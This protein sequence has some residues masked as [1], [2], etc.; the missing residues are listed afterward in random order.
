MKA[1]SYLLPVGV[2][3]TIRVHPGG[4]V[5]LSLLRGTVG[6][7]LVIPT[8]IAHNCCSIKYKVSFQPSVSGGAGIQQTQHCARQRI[9]YFIDLF[10]H[11]KWEGKSCGFATENFPLNS[12]QVKPW[13]SS[14]SSSQLFSSYVLI[15]GRNLILTLIHL[16]KTY[17]QLRSLAEKDRRCSN[18]LQRKATTWRAQR[19][20]EN[21]KYQK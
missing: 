20:S 10:H 15:C 21:C 9:P 3:N 16:S 7:P 17:W 1:K 8:N 13:Y 2:D 18:I 4:T 6:V 11:R 12:S 5:V 14:F 19:D